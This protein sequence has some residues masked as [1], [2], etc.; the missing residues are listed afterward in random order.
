MNRFYKSLPEVLPVH[1]LSTILHK[2]TVADAGKAV[3]LLLLARAA[4][5][6]ASYHVTGG[7]APR[8]VVPATHTVHLEGTPT[9]IQ[10]FLGQIG[11]HDE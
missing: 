8:H 4:C 5:L 2:L 6:K 7:H 9:Q 3:D 11:V 10:S 1:P